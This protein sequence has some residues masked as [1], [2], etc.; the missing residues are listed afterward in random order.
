MHWFSL[1]DVSKETFKGIVYMSDSL[2][3][4]I[5]CDGIVN[6]ADTMLL[7]VVYLLF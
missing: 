5:D 1:S 2:R 7:L 4:R 6:L 3:R